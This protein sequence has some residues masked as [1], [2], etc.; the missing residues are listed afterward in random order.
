MGLALADSYKVIERFKEKSK[1]NR[2]K[3]LL[4]KSRSTKKTTKSSRSKPKTLTISLG[5]YNFNRKKKRYQQVREM[6]GGG[7][8]TFVMDRSSTLQEVKQKAESLFFPNDRSRSGKRKCEFTIEIADFSL[9]V[10]Q[11]PSLTV[12]QYLET[13]NITS[14]KVNLLSKELARFEKLEKLVSSNNLSDDSDMEDFVEETN[15]RR[16]VLCMYYKDLNDT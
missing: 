11:D 2:L 10:F 4:A 3:E 9:T 1:E 15:L 7:R 5:W 12:E 6:Q 8:R 14:A 16:N 13:S